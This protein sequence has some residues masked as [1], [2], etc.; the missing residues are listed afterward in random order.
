VANPHQADPDARRRY[1]G[2]MVQQMESGGYEAMLGELLQRDI[3]EWNPERIPETEA[4]RRQKEI[5][6]LADPVCSFLY[7]RLT[8]GTHITTGEGSVGS[9]IYPWATEAPTKVHARDL[10]AEF[11]AYCETRKLPCSPVRLARELPRYLGESFRRLSVRSKTADGSEPVKAYEFPPLE[12]ARRAFE[13]A[14]GL[15]IEREEEDPEPVP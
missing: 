6:Q 4:L 11:A 15:R 14:T 13:D 9:P 8:D 12:E 10:I 5:N 2:E 1:F 7:E 3:T